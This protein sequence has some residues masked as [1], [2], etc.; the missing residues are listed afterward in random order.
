M[1]EANLIHR[2]FEADNGH[3]YL[4]P[5]NIVNAADEV[6]VNTHDPNSRGYGGSVFH[7]ETTEG[8][9]TVKGPWHGSSPYRVCNVTELHY[10]KVTLVA[11]AEYVDYNDWVD[12]V[13]EHGG[14]K[15]CVVCR[16]RMIGEILYDEKEWVLGTFY[17]GD[18]I[19]QQ[20]ADLRKEPIFVNVESMGGGH[21]HEAK[22]GGELHPL[23]HRSGR[24]RHNDI[25]A[26][27]GGIVSA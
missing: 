12:H 8:T 7:F 26:E 1:A 21:S 10:T 14:D 15:D 22:P 13:R 19:A 6:H 17:R 11:R 3:T 2:K 16:F 23:A 5:V 25:S 24:N 9:E 27:Q 18:R 4:I 20:L